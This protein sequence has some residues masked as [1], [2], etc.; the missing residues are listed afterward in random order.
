MGRKKNGEIVAF[1]YFIRTNEEK[2]LQKKGW[3]EITN[4]GACNSH[5]NEGDVL[6]G[7]TLSSKIPNGGNILM[8]EVLK[9]VDKGFYNGIKSIY[10]CSRV[11][12]LKDKK[13][14]SVE[15]DPTVKLFKRHNFKIIKLEKDGY[16]DDIDSQGYS[17][18]VKRAIYGNIL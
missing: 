2:I 3:D 5:Q 11:P 17:L 9:Q 10:A 4:N 8:G 1:I 7:V 13:D 14:L 18:L 12:T 15:K 16:K 6:F